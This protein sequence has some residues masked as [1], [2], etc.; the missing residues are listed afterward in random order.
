VSSFLFG[1]G[2]RILLDFIGV[3]Q[4]VITIIPIKGILFFQRFRFFESTRIAGGF[5]LVFDQH[6]KKPQHFTRNAVV[7]H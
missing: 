3:R 4:L 5:M 2:D 6:N 1:I 7:N